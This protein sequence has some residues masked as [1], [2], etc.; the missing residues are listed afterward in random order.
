MF[1]CMCT[2]EHHLLCGRPVLSGIFIII[3][4]HLRT[5]LSFMFRIMQKHLLH[6]K[7]SLLIAST[8]HA[9]D[10]TLSTPICS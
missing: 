3:P 8:L 1:L 5:H 2:T 9:L 7:C 4:C 6:K 10:N